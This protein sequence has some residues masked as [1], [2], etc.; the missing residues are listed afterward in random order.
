MQR[1]LYGDF[2]F[3]GG[4]GGDVVRKLGKEFILALGPFLLFASKAFFLHA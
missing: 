2:F 4:R 1:L 3:C